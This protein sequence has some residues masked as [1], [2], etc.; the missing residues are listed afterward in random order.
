M[1]KILFVMMM[2][3]TLFCSGWPT[4]CCAA[5]I[6]ITGITPDGPCTPQQ[7]EAQGYCNYNVHWRIGH[8]SGTW[9][10]VGQYIALAQN[11]DINSPLN[12]ALS[13]PQTVWGQWYKVEL[14][15]WFT[16]YRIADYSSWSDL[17]SAIE[18]DYGT[19]G[20]SADVQSLPGSRYAC[21]QIVS[22]NST[23]TNYDLYG[24]SGLPGS[25]CVPIPAIQNACFFQTSTIE[26]NHGVLLPSQM[27]GHQARTS[28]TAVCSQSAHA[29]IYGPGAVPLESENYQYSIPSQISIDGQTLNNKGVK[30]K[31]K[32]GENTID[33]GD[34][35]EGTT[36]EG[37]G[38]YTGS[39]VLII[40]IL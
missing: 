3:V 11:S 16:S 40:S 39:T 18:K 25:A 33:V 32:A 35:L 12:S 17:Q 9:P 13:E 28:V 26:L 10:P 27:M 22:Y 38:V 2:M 36:E 30:L 4:S 14:G 5:L 34:T 21:A 15:S 29:V 8:P 23:D 31:L 1:S 20:I 24:V 6:D 7:V 19:Q 37:G